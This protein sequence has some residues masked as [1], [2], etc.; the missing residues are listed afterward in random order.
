MQTT[1]DFL[2]LETSSRARTA[3]IAVPIV[4]LV[5]T[6]GL[7]GHPATR[8]Q[9]R[10]WLLYENSPVEL[11]TFG[12]F[13]LGGLGGL[14]LAARAWRMG[15]GAFTAAFF[16]LYSLGLIFVAGEEIAW[17]QWFFHWATPASWSAVN[18]QHETTLH[19]V[20]WLNDF[21]PILH[22][23][24]A[25]GALVGTRVGRVRLLAWVATPRVLTSWFILVGVHSTCELVTAALWRN[26]IV[27][28]L[29]ERTSEL[30]ELFLA[31]AAWLYVFLNARRAARE[32]G[33]VVSHRTKRASAAHSG[34]TSI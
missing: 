19:N 25:V 26:S 6:A 5:I 23:T 34:G 24:F 20:S 32:A 3:F 9:A 29:F 14:A 22:I 13:L 2:Q 7:L 11:L 33:V 17:G 30:T 12:F 21:I 4:L 18:A 15:L 1:D 27:H 8:V 16:A 31:I 28:K 10:P